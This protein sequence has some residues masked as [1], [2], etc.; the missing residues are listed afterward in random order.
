[1]IRP[2][3]SAL[4]FCLVLTSVVIALTAN[5]P[6][7]YAAN[8]A[9]GPRLAQPAPPTTAAPVMRSDVPPISQPVLEVATFQVAPVAPATM[10]AR[11]KNI[12]RLAPTSAGRPPGVRREERQGERVIEVRAQKSERWEDLFQRVAATLPVKLPAGAAQARQM[13]LPQLVPGK[14][15]RVRAFAE[16]VLE[17]EYVVTPEEAYGLLLSKTALQVRPLAGD[18]RL[19]ERMRADPSKA[20]LFTA[21]DAIGLPENIALQLT[22]IFSG[23]VDFLRELHQGYRCAIV[24]EA[25]YREGFIERSGRI[26]AAELDVGK[27][28]YRAYYSPDSKGQGR[29][30]DASGK[31]TQRVF[32]R[33]PLEFTR[34]TSEFTLARFHPILG[35]WT[36]HR[37]VDY[38]APT[39]TKIMSVAD[40]VV[41]FV[42]ERGG[43]GNLVIVR[44]Q[45]KFLTYYAHMDAFVP[46]LAAGRKVTQGEALGFVGMTGLATGPHLHFEFHVKSAAGEWNSVPAPDVFDTTIAAAPG[47]TDR[48]RA[49]R[50]GLTAAGQGNVLFLE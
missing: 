10:D 29:Y 17:F 2:M 43:Y 1:M 34:V 35:V 16:D 19:V 38:A 12:L 26:L 3:R 5:V 40:G 28:N 8:A 23:E 30:F 37:G 4:S 39:G 50:D 49:Y 48:V 32:R 21:T 9:Q 11:L 6:R 24:Y 33:S 20:S 42:G 45:E 15:L 27:R 7:A 18:P 47:F 41:D 25:H 44:H 31:T 46:K 36:A 22:E 13:A 14:Y